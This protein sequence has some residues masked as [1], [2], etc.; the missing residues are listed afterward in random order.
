MLH[1]FNTQD[2]K[3]VARSMEKYVAT[4][5]FEMKL[6]H[7]MDTL[8]VMSGFQNWAGLKNWLSETA[9]NARLSDVELKHIRESGDENYGPE[10]A[11]VGH[12]GFELRYPAQGELEY[13]RVC[14]PLGRETAYWDSDEWATS[15]QDVMGA[16]LGALA[17]RS[18]VT[19]GIR[20]RAQNVMVPEVKRQVEKDGK[21]LPRIVDV[22]FDRVI[23]V[24]IGQR[25]Y[26]V[27]FADQEVL[28]GLAGQAQDEDIESD[29]E[30]QALQIGE[31]GQSISLA[32]LRELDWSA[33]ERCFVDQ[34]GLA[35]RF[36][37][38]V[39]FDDI[40]QS[41]DEPVSVGYKSAIK[42]AR[43]EIYEMRA[44]RAGQMTTMRVVAE[45]ETLALSKF[46]LEFG[47][48][49][50]TEMRVVSDFEAGPFEVH[51]DGGLYDRVPTLEHAISL[52]EILESA[53]ESEV[54]IFDKRGELLWNLLVS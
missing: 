26:L 41:E 29:V 2:A 13:V 32:T 14:D 15:P 28:S 4:L 6:G 48:D 43:P 40:W 21:R 25:W 34:D 11:L 46:H 45:T 3:V 36:N 42:E 38:S 30:H 5:G 50:L 31:Q 54:E 20:K 52:A 53:A 47:Q 27:T 37:I 9:V 22:P 33:T 24:Q 16:I 23:S 12:T 10:Y 19:V 17:Q 39:P 1:I 8:G 49:N 7:A 51:V 44:Q 18:P 35:Y